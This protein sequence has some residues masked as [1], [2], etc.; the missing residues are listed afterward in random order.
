MIARQLDD[1]G[2]KHMTHTSLK[3]KHIQALANRW[4]AEGI[5]IGTIK[6]RMSVLRW[7]A[8]Q[9][10]KPNVVLSNDA[11]GIDKRETTKESKAQS[12]DQ[13]KLK[14]INSPYYYCQP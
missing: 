14:Q 4:Q 12:L 11:Y 3:Q 9:I 8:E 10:G 2:F 1:L 6:N 7:W 5:T 13:D